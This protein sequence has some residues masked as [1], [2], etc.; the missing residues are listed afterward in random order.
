ME[1][2]IKYQRKDI[3]NKLKLKYDDIIRIIKH[4]NNSI[5]TNECSLWDSDC[6]YFYFNKKKHSLQ[7]LLYINFIDDLHDNE[8]IKFNCPNKN[9]CCCINHIYKKNNEKKKII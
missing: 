6:T 2:F 5:F 7:R 1:Q 4:T 9:I 8:Y 3:P